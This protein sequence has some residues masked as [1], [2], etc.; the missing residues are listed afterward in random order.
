MAAHPESP[1]QLPEGVGGE[2]GDLH[3]LVPDSICRQAE[4]PG[5]LRSALEAR[6][7]SCKR[8]V[9]FVFC[10]LVAQCFVRYSSPSPY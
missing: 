3:T 7:V 9:S 8:S 1:D 10:R 6:A 5:P 4:R 2:E